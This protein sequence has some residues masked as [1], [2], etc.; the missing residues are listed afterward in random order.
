MTSHTHYLAWEWHPRTGSTR[1]GWRGLPLR[2]W[3]TIVYFVTWVPHQLAAI[4]ELRSEVSYLEG[5][6]DDVLYV[7]EDIDREVDRRLDMIV[8]F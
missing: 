6:L 7:I 8:P 1:R 4:D 2:A 3:R 5:R